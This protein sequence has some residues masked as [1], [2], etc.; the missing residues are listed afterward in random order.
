MIEQA[1]HF[2]LA[3]NSVTFD[4]PLNLKSRVTEKS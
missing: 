3:I 1:P 4:L 2:R